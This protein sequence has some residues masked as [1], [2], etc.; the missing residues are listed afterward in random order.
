M[1]YSIMSAS[2]TLTLVDADR[3]LALGSVITQ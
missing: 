1:I 3:R 2:L